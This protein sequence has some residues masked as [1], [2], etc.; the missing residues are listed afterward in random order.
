MIT[1]PHIVTVSTT[2]YRRRRCRQIVDFTV[3]R[4][5]GE[6]EGEHSELVAN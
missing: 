4:G 2:A 6:S 3:R 5:Q 1:V